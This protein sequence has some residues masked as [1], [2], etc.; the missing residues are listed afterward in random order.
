[1]IYF[2]LLVLTYVIDGNE[3]VSQVAF[4]DQSGCAIAM[5]PIFDALRAQHHDSVA[6]CTP[7]S[8]PSGY[9]IRPK[10]RPTK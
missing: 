2:H 10:P 3:Y 1:M 6:Q 9:T 5:D 8:T 7:T 4:K